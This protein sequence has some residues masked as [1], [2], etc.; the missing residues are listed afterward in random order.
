MS[1]RDRITFFS[2]NLLRGLIWLAGIIVIYILIREYVDLNFEKILEPLYNDPFYVYL[3]FSISE[4]LVGIIP[5]ELFMI[6][7]SHKGSLYEYIPSILLLA[8][9][10]YGAGIL[11]YWIGR[12]FS[13]TQLYA[14]L[15]DRFFSDYV[16]TLRRYGSFLIVVAALTP[17]PFSGIA[18]VVGST[19]YR[20]E[21]YVLISL[22]RFFRFGVYAYVVWLTV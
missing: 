3:A 4:V 19:G 22:T 12:S 14:R 5:P 17:L 1:N 9:L 11:G 6:W 21:K 8:V 7:A 10:S 18:M 20:F 2:K 15:S 16:D 13:D